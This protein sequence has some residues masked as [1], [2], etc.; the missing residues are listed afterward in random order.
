MQEKTGAVSKQKVGTKIAYKEE[1]EKTDVLPAPAG[2]ERKMEA[3]A[4]KFG[5]L[6]DL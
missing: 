2:G 1:M 6:K 3:T 5:L 4:M